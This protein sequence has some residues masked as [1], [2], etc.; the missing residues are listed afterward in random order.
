MDKISERLLTVYKPHCEN[1]M[2][3]AMVRFEG[4]SSLKQYMPA[5]PVKRGI[6][7]W[8][9]ADAHNGYLCEYKVYTGRSEGYRVGLARVLS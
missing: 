6:K 4:R 5:K 1:S 3:E 9:H 7:V 2:D 8:C